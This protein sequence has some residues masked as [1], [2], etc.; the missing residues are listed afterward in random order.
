MRQMSDSSLIS[1][2]FKYIRANIREQ[3]IKLRLISYRGEDYICKF[4]GV[5]Y[6]PV[7]CLRDSIDSYF[8]GKS[9]ADIRSELLWKIYETLYH[10]ERMN[11]RISMK[12]IVANPTIYLSDNVCPYGI[13][14]KMYGTSFSLVGNK[15]EVFPLSEMI[16][17]DAGIKFRDVLDMIRDKALESS[18]DAEKARSLLSLNPEISG[19]VRYVLES[20]QCIK[21]EDEM[22]FPSSV[23]GFKESIMKIS[24]NFPSRTFY[25]VFLNNKDV[26]VSDSKHLTY[27]RPKENLISLSAVLCKNL[28][29]R[30]HDDIK[31]F[32]FSAKSFRLFACSDA[33]IV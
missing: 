20:L 22:V 25:V 27:K 5:I 4:D 3:S 12:E 7:I 26:L 13:Y 31:L 15:G 1:Y 28:K 10:P 14:M 24:E 6:V 8:G 11:V 16:L 19:K 18:L 21:L 30:N 2:L 9:I 29:L 17:E 23:L 32:R 33:F